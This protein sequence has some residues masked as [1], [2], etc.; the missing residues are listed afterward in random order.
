MAVTDPR[1]HHDDLVEW[2]VEEAVD[3]ETFVEY[4]EM[5][6][7]RS[8][9]V[10]TGLVLDDDDRLLLAYDDDDGQWLAPGGTLQPGES[11]A[12]GLR[13]EVREE[14]GVEATMEQPLGICDVVTRNEDADGGEA[15]SFTV[16]FAAA[17]AETTAVGEELGGDDEA[18]TD[19]GWFEELPGDVYNREG[20]EELLAACDRWE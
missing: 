19:A 1:E 5:E 3:A 2:H 11:L 20:T 8:G 10:A 17:T 16:V 6:A 13:R 12:E 18:I 7:Y 9:W 15:V 14:T 4:S